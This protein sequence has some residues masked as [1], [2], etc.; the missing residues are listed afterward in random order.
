LAL[1]RT[2]LVA[3]AKLLSQRY[4]TA[5]K[6]TYSNGELRKAAY[7]NIANWMFGKMKRGDRRILPSC[8]VSAIR[9][10]FPNPPGKRYVGFLAPY[11]RA[12]AADDGSDS[13]VDFAYDSQDEYSAD[14]DDS[15]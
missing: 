5:I 15:D 13:E 9:Q 1:D 3:S 4:G 11:E 10:V 6:E 14:T 12:V 7:Y 8:V 2:V